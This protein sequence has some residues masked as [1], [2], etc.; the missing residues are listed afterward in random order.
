MKRMKKLSILVVAIAVAAIF[1]SAFLASAKPQGTYA[2]KYTTGPL[3]IPSGTASLN[4]N[5]LNDDSKTQTVR[6]TVYKCYILSAKTIWTPGVSIESTL[7]PGEATHNANNA[8]GLYLY[9]IVVETNSKMVFPS[10]EAW[11][12]NVGIAIP[13]SQITSAEFIREMP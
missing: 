12:S 13:G 2:Y 11:P 5:V 3:T 6:V 7:A 8:F 9:E 1:L 10:A 4:W